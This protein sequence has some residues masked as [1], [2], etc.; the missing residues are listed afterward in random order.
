MVRAYML[1]RDDKDAR[2]NMGTLPKFVSKYNQPIAAKL[3][4]TEF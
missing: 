1:N 4:K 2:K 3:T